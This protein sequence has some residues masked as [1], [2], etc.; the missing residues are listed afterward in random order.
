MKRVEVNRSQDI[1]K[2]IFAKMQ[3]VQEKGPDTP[4]N[5]NA[6]RKL[7]VPEK[8]CGGEQRSENMLERGFEVQKSRTRC[9][10][11]RVLAVPLQSIPCAFSAGWGDKAPKQKQMKSRQPL[12]GVYNKREEEL[13]L[14]LGRV[15]RVYR[16]RI[17]TG[18]KGVLVGVSSETVSLSKMP[19][20]R[21][22][23]RSSKSYKRK[24]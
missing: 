1:K 4:P 24:V 13:R 23:G 6:S 5:G 12:G 16:W 21:K 10:L 20:R 22:G 8:A 15:V 3:G 11:S 18:K 7:W 9:P 17:V 14:V 19:E 2:T